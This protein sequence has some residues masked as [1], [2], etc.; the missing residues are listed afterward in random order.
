MKRIVVTGAQGFVGRHLV[1][2]IVTRDTETVVL[3][4]GRAERHEAFGSNLSFGA[5]A[6]PAPLPSPL[7]DASMDARYDYACADLND[8]SAVAEL[9]RRVRPT[10][11]VHLAAVLGGDDAA[12]LFRTN[13]GGTVALF[14]AVKQAGIAPCVVIGSSGGVYGASPNVPFHES[15][16][17]TP[18]DT[19]SVSK[20]AQE[21][22]ASFAGRLQ[23]LD[24]RIARMFNI[25][26]PG[27]SERH[28]CARFASQIARRVVA[29]DTSPV[30]I[31]DLTPTRDFIDARDVAL[32][33]LTIVENG[34][35]D[36][37]YNVG[38]GRETSMRT[39]F[40]ITCNAAGLRAPIA[41]RTTY[42][43]RAEIVRHVADV[44][45]LRSLGYVGR[46]SL[47]ES[48]MDLMHYYL[49][50]LRDREYARTGSMSTV[51]Q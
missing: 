38:S 29:G 34:S 7:R 44:A 16:P 6:V 4:I 8:V 35:R 49:T 39:V 18:V 40:D 50:A 15:E 32:A 31:G 42:H 2:A 46:Y 25:V 26:G 5:T 23:G 9:L 12:A 51:A 22:A 47:E 11:I 1:Q 33:I 20:L 30:E 48:V 21:R 45:R 28:A 14:D 24:V 19:Y 27:L 43:R 17:C 37:V 13:V 10:T 3:G 41:S 36:G